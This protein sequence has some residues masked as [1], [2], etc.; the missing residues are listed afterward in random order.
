[1]QATIHLHSV[2]LQLAVARAEQTLAGTEETAD[3][4]VAV[5]LLEDITLVVLHPLLGKEIMEVTA[6]EAHQLVQVV[7]AVQ[8]LSAVTTLD[9]L[10]EKEEMAAHG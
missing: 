9:P 1:M 5:A 10:L 6:L 7:V 3:L 8:E 2:L 4:A